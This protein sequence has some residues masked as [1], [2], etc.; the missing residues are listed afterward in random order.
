MAQKCAE[1]KQGSCGTV[2]QDKVA[3]RAEK[4][5]ASGI[6]AAGVC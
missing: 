6:Q 2:M 5:H 1:G 4:C 3:T